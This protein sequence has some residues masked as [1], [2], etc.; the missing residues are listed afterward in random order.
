M[1]CVTGL[2]GVTCSV[3]LCNRGRG[4]VVW[5]GVAYDIMALHDGVWWY[6]VLYKYGV[7]TCTVVCRCVMSRDVVMCGH[8][9]WCTM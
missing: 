3:M 5:C 1:R 2:W 7:V 6:V 9:C 8:V 4:C